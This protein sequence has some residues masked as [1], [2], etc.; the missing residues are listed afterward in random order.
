MTRRLA[1]Y[2]LVAMAALAAG[3]F[4]QLLELSS[5][6][7]FVLA[8]AVLVASV[9]A[10][11]IWAEVAGSSRGAWSSPLRAVE[12]EQRAYRE[13]VRFEAPAVE[14]AAVIFRRWRFRLALA[15][16]GCALVLI[17]VAGTGAVGLTGQDVVS[18]V[19]VLFAVAL[20]VV[21]IPPK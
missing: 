21:G 1:A 10:V 9:S 12:A 19:I 15:M 18:G 6:G 4:G 17:A 20:A 16:I 3:A 2:P 7:R 11:L 13:A 8:L 14:A 5:V